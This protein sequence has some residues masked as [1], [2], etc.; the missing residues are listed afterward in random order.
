MKTKF[1]FLILPQIHLLD[2]AGPDQT[3]HE[4]IEYG[5]DFEIDYCTL[6]N[7]VNSTAGLPLGKIQHFSKIKF[8]AGDFLMIPGSNASYLCSTSFKDNKKIFDWI[9][10][11]YTSGL[12]ICSICAGAFVLA[13]AG[14]LNNIECTTHFK[15]TKQLQ[16]MYPKTKVVEN[17]LFTTQN[18]I[19]TSAGIASGIDLTLH[20]IQSLKGDYFAH[21][22]ARELVVY[23][24]RN[25]NMAQQSDMLLHRN[26]IHYGIHKVQ[27][28]LSENLSKKISLARLAEVANMSERNFT[29]IFKKETKLT[30][31]EY[32]NVLRKEKITELIKNPNLSMIEI[33]NKVG[34]NS[35][36]QVSRIKNKV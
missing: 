35:E 23:N 2:L 33:A 12:N 9:N 11:L 4:A 13:E 7:T 28:L 5:A 8:K 14:L 10:A 6:E 32:L 26:H 18:R 21:K 29:R 36:R 17:I 19:Y 30:V 22:V 3:I 27:D 31:V 15:K 24:R 16:S 34:L 1:I 25:G 20:I